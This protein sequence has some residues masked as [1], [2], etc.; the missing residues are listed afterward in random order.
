[1]ED[2]L[3]GHEPKVL[4]PLT[5]IPRVI[6]INSFSRLTT[7]LPSTM[8]EEEDIRQIA[9]RSI[10]SKCGS[11]VIVTAT[12]RGKAF[13]PNMSLVCNPATRQMTALPEDGQRATVE[14]P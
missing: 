10:T 9:A 6:T 7:E 4:A 14:P 5:W 11:L 13:H 12:P 2:L 3:D 1:V 8:E